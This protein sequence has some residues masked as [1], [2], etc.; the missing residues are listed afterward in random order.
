MKEFTFNGLLVQGLICVDIVVFVP[1]LVLVEYYLRVW[2][3]LRDYEG[4]L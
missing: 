2:V 3:S 1:V 4:A